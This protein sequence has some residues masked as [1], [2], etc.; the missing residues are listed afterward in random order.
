MRWNGADTGRTLGQLEAAISN[1]LEVE[2]SPIVL[3]LLHARLAQHDGCSRFGTRD[4]LLLD[5]PNVK[6]MLDA[7]A[8][9]KAALV[10]DSND[11]EH[12]ALVSLVQALI[13]LKVPECNCI[14][15]EAPGTP[16]QVHCPAFAWQKEGN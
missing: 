15:E 6:A 2:P 3:A 1:W 4:L 14:A 10:G 7:I 12:D 13:G 8:D 11:A 5:K 16:H 9:A